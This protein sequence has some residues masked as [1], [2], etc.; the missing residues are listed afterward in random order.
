M[1]SGRPDNQGGWITTSKYIT[2]TKIACTAA[3]TA[4]TLQGETKAFEVYNHGPNTM[5]M[6]INGVADT[7]DRPM[8]PKTSR[9]MDVDAD[10]IGLICAAGQTASVWVT[11]LG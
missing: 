3:H 9:A 7:N 6:L 4:H 8:G 5:Y 11:E 1:A 10:S 2:E